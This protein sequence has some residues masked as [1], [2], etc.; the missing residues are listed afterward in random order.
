MSFAIVDALAWKASQHADDLQVRGNNHER[1][2]DLLA[3]ED[4]AAA[5]EQVRVLAEAYHR[6]AADLRTTIKLLKGHT[7]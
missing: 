7:Q 6:T 4:F 3:D 1:I 5:A 2:A